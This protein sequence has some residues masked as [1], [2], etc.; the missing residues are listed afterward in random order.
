VDKRQPPH[1]EDALGWRPA[2]ESA[3]GQGDL[4]KGYQ[5]R[6]LFSAVEKVKA[7]PKVEQPVIREATTPK[8]K[9]KK[10]KKGR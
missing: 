5:V 8:S 2:G 7:Q 6:Q 4:A 10:S 1:L 9:K 3:T